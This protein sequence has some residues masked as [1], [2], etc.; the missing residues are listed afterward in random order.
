MENAVQRQPWKRSCRTEFRSTIFNHKLCDYY[1]RCESSW[2]QMIH[3]K[4][5]F[6]EMSKFQGLFCT[7]LYN[8]I[9]YTSEI[10]AQYRSQ[11]PIW[12]SQTFFGT[13]KMARAANTLIILRISSKNN[14]V[15]AGFQNWIVRHDE[16]LNKL[17]SNV[18]K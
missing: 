7:K 16:C 14:V 3:N 8:M 12:E 9:T 18:K 2:G 4:R 6:Y 13:K 10:L 11:T 1:S 15:G 17:G 5:T